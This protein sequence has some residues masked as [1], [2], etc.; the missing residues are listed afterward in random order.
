M[1]SSIDIA[2]RHF[3]R[4]IAIAIAVYLVLFIGVHTLFQSVQGPAEVA[5]ELLPMLPMAF[6]FYTA[7]RWFAQTDELKRKIVTES[8]AV[9]GAVTLFVLLGAGFLTDDA[10]VTVPA[11]GVVMFFALVMC[12]T[13]VV[14][15]RRYL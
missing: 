6:I 12:A 13:S 4:N 10:P 3:L 14:L 9:A 15:K 2:R 8:F 5:L 1:T 7:I 11:W